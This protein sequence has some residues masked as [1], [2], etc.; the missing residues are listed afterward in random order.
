MHFLHLQM[1]VASELHSNAKPQRISK[2]NLG[3][4]NTLL[5]LCMQST[6]HV[7]LSKRPEGI[8]HVL[9]RTK[10]QQPLSGT[11]TASTGLADADLSDANKPAAEKSS[12][13][14]DSLSAPSAEEHAPA[15]PLSTALPSADTSDADKPALQTV[16][17]L[18]GLAADSQ[19]PAET[20]HLLPASASQPTA[21]AAD[22][23]AG[24]SH[25]AQE[26]SG[27]PAVEKVDNLQ[28]LSAASALEPEAA[29]IGAFT[30]AP[31]H[32]IDQVSRFIW[33]GA[34]AMTMCRSVHH[35]M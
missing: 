21:P 28:S 9:C 30:P 35:R 27:K 20:N 11:L 31:E 3:L 29:S 17:Q 32:I 19:Q 23:Q 15:A 1:Q 6:S 4:S 22:P 12:N 24:L 33:A 14:Q 16:P 34:C 26:E 10:Q 18:L 8:R 5:P 13:L 7:L 2:L 25:F